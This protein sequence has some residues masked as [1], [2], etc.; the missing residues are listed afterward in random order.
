MKHVFGKSN[1]FLCHSRGGLKTKTKV[2]VGSICILSTVAGVCA[3]NIAANQVA[4]EAYN[5]TQTGQSC[6]GNMTFQVNVV[7]SLTVELTTPSS[8]ASGGMNTFL[9]NNVN[10]AVSTNNTNGFTA[11]M[12]SSNNTTDLTNSAAST[13]LPTL[14]SD[15]T[16]GSFPSNHWGYSL[17]DY[18][19]AGAS[20]T[21]E[22]SEGSG[23]ST[24]KNL[25]S[26]SATPITVLSSTT[27]ASDSQDIY[28]G[29]K[30]DSSLASG[31]Y[32]GTVIISVVTG[33]ITNDN[34]ITPTNPAGPSTDTTPNDYIATY[35]GTS[36]TTG[37]ST[38]GTTVYT[39]TSSTA[40]TDTTTTRIEEGDTTTTYR[41]PQ[42]VVENTSARVNGNTPL[43][44]GLAVAS[45]VAATSGIIF[46]ILAKRKKDD[47]EEEEEDQA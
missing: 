9:R 29:A 4:A 25:V 31:T 40:S 22:T 20:G 7:E 11:S 3:G 16:R 15:S 13:T 39:T 21:S 2:I 36:T 45:T 6:E 30:A 35:T 19:K 23:S 18:T 5:C 41:G 42:G 34:P 38:N 43:A 14:T 44:T 17:G 46:F 1:I 26:T 32:S 10:L 28:F 27:A 24:Y 8:Q 33:D 37:G 12:Y 47:D